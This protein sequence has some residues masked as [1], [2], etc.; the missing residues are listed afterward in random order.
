MIEFQILDANLN[1]AREGLRVVEDYVRFAL[2]NEAM[3]TKLKEFRALLG[4][5]EHRYEQRLIESR[6]SEQDIGRDKDYPQR[7]DMRSVVVANIKRAQEA[8]RVI[9]ELLKVLNDSD[10]ARVKDMRYELYTF[11]KIIKEAKTW[12]NGKQHSKTKSHHK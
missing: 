5:I 10:F 6:D 8:A 4:S 7:P 9:E 1:R 3:Q 11:E 12:H 2:K